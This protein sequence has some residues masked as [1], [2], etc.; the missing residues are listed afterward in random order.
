M[1]P[2]QVITGRLLP[3]ISDDLQQFLVALLEIDA[4]LHEGV[5]L[6]SL[7]LIEVV[8]LLQVNVHISEHLQSLSELLLFLLVLASLLLPLLLLLGKFLLQ[9]TDL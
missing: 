9:R 3:L 7:L 5:C 6:I 8:E 1:G 2:V 4:T